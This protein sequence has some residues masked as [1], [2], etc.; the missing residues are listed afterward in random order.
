NWP[1]STLHTRY[2][3]TLQHNAWAHSP[4]LNLYHNARFFPPASLHREHKEKLT[5]SLFASVFIST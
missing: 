4:R 2:N 5:E 1:M 3:L